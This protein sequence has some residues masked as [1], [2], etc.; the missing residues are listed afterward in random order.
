LLET[1]YDNETKALAALTHFTGQIPLKFIAELAAL[2]EPA[3]QGALSDLSSRALVLPDLEERN[4]ALVPMVADFLR[5]KKPELVAETGGRLE[6]RAYA[7][8][9]ENGYSNH[10]FFP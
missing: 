8:I 5:K 1:F 2:N 9:V 4:F 3:A 7:L 6:E 10:E